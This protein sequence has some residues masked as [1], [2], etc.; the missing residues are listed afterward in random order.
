MEQEIEEL[1]KV[2]KATLTDDDRNK[3]RYLETQK[4]RFSFAEIGNGITVKFVECSVK[5]GEIEE[6]SKFINQAF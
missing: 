1:R 3:Q 4:K 6:V 2:K 5:T